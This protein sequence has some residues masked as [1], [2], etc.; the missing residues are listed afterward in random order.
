MKGMSSIG[1]MLA[2]I[3]ATLSELCALDALSARSEARAL[4]RRL[5]A[6]GAEEEARAVAENA[7][8]CAYSLRTEEGRPFAGAEEAARGLSLCRLAFVAKRYRELVE[9][10]T[11]EYD[12]A[13]YN[14]GT[15]I[16]R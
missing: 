7:A 12:E 1:I 11:M 10:D 9:E 13:G 8:I 14:T 4:A 2:G 16:N 15:I 3:P 6:Q 5:C